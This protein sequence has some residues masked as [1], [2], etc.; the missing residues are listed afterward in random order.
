MWLGLVKARARP[1]HDLALRYPWVG[2]PGSDHR[3]DP[4]SSRIAVASS[5]A[6]R[7]AGGAIS[8]GECAPPMDGV[9]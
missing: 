3:S 7:G 6:L 1:Y 5:K 4:S 9:E 2:L 8:F